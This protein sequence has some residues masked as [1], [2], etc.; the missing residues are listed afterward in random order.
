MQLNSSHF[1]EWLRV[2]KNQWKVLRRKRQRECANIEK[3]DTELIVFDAVL[4]EQESSSA[5]RTFAFLLD[6]D[7]GCPDD[8][9][10]KVLQYLKPTEHCKFFCINNVTRQAHETGT[11]V[12]TA[13]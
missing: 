7:L 1:A 4:E 8:V 12:A 5:P 3:V 10:V 6:S 2:R 13:L 11:N 9:V